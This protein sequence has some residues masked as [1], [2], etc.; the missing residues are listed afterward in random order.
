MEI[1]NHFFED[2]R[3]PIVSTPNMGGFFPEGLPDTIVLHYTAGSTADSAI[4]TFVNPSNSVSAHMIVDRD[5]SV[6]QLVP[7]NR[8]AWHAGRSRFGDRSG[9][10]AYSIG[11]EMVNAG[12]LEKGGSDY[13][14]WFGKKIPEEEVIEAVHQNEH[15]LSYWQRFT[16]QQLNTV[17]GLCLMLIDV[18]PIKYIV[19]HDEIAPGRKI[20]PGPAFPMDQFR[21]KLLSQN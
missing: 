20:D 6:S 5:G 18:Y 12:R 11:I 8:I 10:N 17:Y 3:I 7:F 2:E 14:S 1:R 13:V 19:G 4:R 16:R 9:L 21:E 15:K